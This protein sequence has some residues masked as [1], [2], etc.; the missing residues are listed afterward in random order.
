MRAPA[1]LLIGSLCWTFAS[2]ASGAAPLQTQAPGHSGA[3]DYRFASAAGL[4]S[5][6]VRPDRAADF[7]AV[8]AKL[9]EVL[10]R[11]A[12]PVR[13]QQAASWRIWR[14]LESGP[15]ATVYIFFFD[16]AVAGADYDPVKILGEGVPT[17][18]HALYERLNAATIK[19]R[20]M[21]LAKI[22]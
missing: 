6:E 5:F 14:S 18:V 10:D 20:R 21:S 11:S 9:S 8:V 2:V 3:P 12:D 1:L 19:V 15:D 4:L 17:E 22:R 7:E 16:P 13:R